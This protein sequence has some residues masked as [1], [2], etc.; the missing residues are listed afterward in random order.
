MPLEEMLIYVRM[1]P[2]SIEGYASRLSGDYREEVG[3]MYSDHIY[4]A[5]ASSASRKDYQRVC[6]ILRHYRQVFGESSQSSMILQL[7]NQYIRKRA[8][9]DELSKVK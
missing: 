5:A 2:S 8:F 4:K 7:K 1:N 3:R 6:D 9:L